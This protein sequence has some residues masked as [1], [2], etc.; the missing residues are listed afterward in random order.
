MEREIV[1]REEQMLSLSSVTRCLS[2][3]Q[4]KGANVAPPKSMTA[5]STSQ[6]MGLGSASPG[7]PS[8]P[9]Q[10]SLI[11]DD[12]LSAGGAGHDGTQ[13]PLGQYSTAQ[14]EKVYALLTGQAG[15]RP[16][17]LHHE[18]LQPVPQPYIPADL[19]PRASTASSVNK[20]RG[21]VAD[22][23][24][25]PLYRKARLSQHVKEMVKVSAPALQQHGFDFNTN[26]LY[27]LDAF[28]D[29][30][31]RGV[32]SA[33]MVST[34]PGNEPSLTNPFTDLS[35]PLSFSSLPSRAAQHIG[36]DLATSKSTAT[37]NVG[38]SKARSTASNVL[39]ASGPADLS[40]GSQAAKLHNSYM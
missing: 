10:S 21:K 7:R 4:T 6:S 5:S 13:Q 31:Q 33:P 11:L 27:V 34:D 25:E 32:S 17:H 35:Q 14:A 39:S 18:P 16:L 28:D 30:Q 15:L 2:C 36:R 12:E 20:L 19:P 38:S 3:G 40:L 29:A 24:P 8:S 23:I 37:M 9:Q 22:K 1:K 26:P